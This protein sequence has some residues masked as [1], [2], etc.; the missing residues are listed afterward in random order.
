[1]T[2]PLAEPKMMNDQ[3]GNLHPTQ[4][5]TRAFVFGMLARII[6]SGL[7]LLAAYGK[8]SDPLHFAEQIR[9]YDLPFVPPAWSHVPAFLLPP[10]ELLTALLLLSGFWRA[11]ARG[12]MFGMLIVFTLMKVS[13]ELRGLKIT[14][15]CF[16]D[17]LGG[18]EQMIN[19]PLGIL[20]NIGLMALLAA[21]W[22]LQRRPAANLA[23]EVDDPTPAAAGA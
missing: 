1:M 10:L 3:T 6:V 2:R 15:G 11:E 16:G 14:C 17:V 21:D 5:S 7:F 22:Y 18:F 19:G 8:L 12:L 9:D 20:F 23:G 4:T 13:V